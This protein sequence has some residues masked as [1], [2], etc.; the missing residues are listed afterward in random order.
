MAIVK[1]KGDSGYMSSNQ[2]R[3]LQLCE[4]IDRVQGIDQ[5]QEELNG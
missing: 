2:L 5:Q 3:E 4:S 1:Q